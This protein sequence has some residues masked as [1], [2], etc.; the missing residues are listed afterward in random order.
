MRRRI[1]PGVA[2]LATTALLLAGCS[3]P[4]VVEAAVQTVTGGVVEQIRP[5]VPERYTASIEPFAQVNLAFKSGGIIEQI[6]QVRG[7]DGRVRDVEPGDRV[8]KDT[9]LAQVRLR[10]YQ[11]RLDGAEAQ[12]AQTEAQHAQTE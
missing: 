5:D 9:V 11:D 8:G 1:L 3:K 7:A 6:H 4:R 10:D 2:I 12:R